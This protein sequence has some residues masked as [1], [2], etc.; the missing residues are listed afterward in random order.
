MSIHDLSDEQLTVLALLP[1]AIASVY[2]QRSTGGDFDPVTRRDLRPERAM[3]RAQSVAREF[4]RW[5][6]SGSK[7]DDLE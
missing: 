4:V 2:G 5:V 3:A 7:L 6:Q 1:G